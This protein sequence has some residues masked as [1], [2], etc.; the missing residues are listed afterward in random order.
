M[1]RRAAS[2]V[3]KGRAFGEDAFIIRQTPG[4]YNEFGEWVPGTEEQ[5]PIRLSSAPTQFVNEF[6]E[7][8]DVLP[9]GARIS[10]VRKFWLTENVEA[11]RVG[12]SATGG[13]RILYKETRFRV[14]LVRDF[15]PHGFIE[16]LAVREEADN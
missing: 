4:E 3:I 10:D 13:D 8:R 15:D 16:A 7:M 9:E 1:S 6:S 12:D 5:I 14:L 2:R 11:L